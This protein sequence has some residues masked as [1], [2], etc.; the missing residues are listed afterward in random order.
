M[1]LALSLVRERLPHVRI[2]WQLSDNPVFASGDTPDLILHFGALP[3]T[4]AWISTTLFRAPERLIASAHY[5][6]EKGLPESLEQ[7]TEHP[8]LVWKPPLEEAELLHLRAGG[9]LRVAPAFVSADVHLVRC[10]ALAGQGIAYVPD[11]GVPEVDREVEVVPVLASLVGRDQSL[12]ALV[13]TSVATLPTGQRL[14]D[15]IR[16]LSSLLLT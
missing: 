7:L 9:Q 14:L 2:N 6:A 4:G 1:T 12:R 10:L 15:V 8:L 5:A 16:E 13:P 11:G 3:A